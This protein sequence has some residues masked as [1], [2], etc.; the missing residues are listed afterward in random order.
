MRLGDLLGMS[1]SSLFKRKVRT[2]LTVLGVVIGTTSIVV[3]ISLGIGMK[4][5]LLEEMENYGSL[6]A[7]TVNSPD[8]GGGMM[9]YDGMSS[10]SGSSK[11]GEERHLDDALIEQ[12]STLDHVVAVDPMLNCSVI[13]KCKGYMT[14]NSVIGSTE[15]Y[16]KRQNIP[17]GEGA[18][19]SSTTELTFLYGNTVLQDMTNEKTNKAYWETGELPPIDWM[20]DQVFVGDGADDITGGESEGGTEC[21]EGGDEHRDDDF[22][23]LLLFHGR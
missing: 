15:D 5:T 16:F 2:I 22:D 10:S 14:W 20:K 11:E 7:I 21:G 18:L 12:L 13:L 19:P 6:T 4:Q 9:Y 17:I 1:I 3:M 23:D 8:G